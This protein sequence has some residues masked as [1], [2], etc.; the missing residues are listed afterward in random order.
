MLRN[1]S[2]PAVN[3][4]IFMGNLRCFRWNVL[5]R[6]VPWVPMVRMVFPGPSSLAERLCSYWLILR[7]A[8]TKQYG[9]FHKWGYPQIIHVNGI[10]PYEPTIWGYPHFWKPPYLWEFHSQFMELRDFF[11]DSFVDHNFDF[12]RCVSETRKSDPSQFF[13]D[14]VRSFR[15]CDCK[16]SI[17]LLIL[18][19]NVIKSP[20]F[21]N[22][23]LWT[24][25]LSHGD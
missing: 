23:S 9:G 5:R 8:N 15:D 12:K 17:A 19:K 10:F 3:Q 1:R 13:G 24:P 7:R 2:G 18:V 22:C 20:V 25:S 14:E 11:G 4:E 6:V 16:L 21:F